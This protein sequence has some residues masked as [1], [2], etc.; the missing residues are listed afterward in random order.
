MD[1]LS[2]IEQLEY[3]LVYNKGKFVKT[4]KKPGRPKAG[5][6]NGPKTS[7]RPTPKGKPNARG[8]R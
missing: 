1:R 7:E 8:R 5:A 3:Q 4:D 2:T 6:K